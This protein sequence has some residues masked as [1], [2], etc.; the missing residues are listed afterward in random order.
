MQYDQASVDFSEVESWIIRTLCESQAS[1]YVI[2]E[3]VP[4]PS[5]LFCAI[6]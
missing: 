6:Q 2:D 4:V 5:C 3:F 1:E